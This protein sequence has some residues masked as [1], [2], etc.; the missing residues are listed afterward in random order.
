[1]VAK[2]NFGYY[3][4]SF[5]DLLA[6]FNDNQVA[7]FI[8]TSAVARSI[9]DNSNPDVGI[10]YL[11]T[12]EDVEREGVYA[13][14]GA[15]CIPNNLDENEEKGV[16]EFLKFATSEDVQADWSGGTGY[17][18]VNKK[19]YQTDN[20]KKIIEEYPGIQV[21][22]DQLLTS[23]ATKATA[24]PL[25]SILPQL[26]SDLSMALEMVFTG[27]SAEEAVN[28]AAELTNGY[29]EQSNAGNAE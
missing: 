17:F 11:P 22:A 26:R 29:I 1:M 21:A 5:D 14:G 18:P 2:D 24:G 25:L 20:W 13:A 23:K 16:V 6:A 7:M 8:T 27:T 4:S 19:T 10:G 9:I 3:G 15:I 12:F 28:Q